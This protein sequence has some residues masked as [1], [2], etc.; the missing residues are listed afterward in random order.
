MSQHT[1]IADVAKAAGVSVTTVSRILNGNY[2]KMR[3]STRHRVEAVIK[4]LNYMPA[5]SAQRLRQ[6]HGHVI[7]VLVGDISNPFSSLLAK[8][9]DDV[10]Q[11]SGYD[12]ILMNTNNS[13]EAEARSL[14]RLYQQQVDG[15]I[16]QPDSRHFQPFNG[17]VQAGVPLVVVDREID[18]QPESVPKVTSCNKD[19]CYQ[20]GKTLVARHYQNIVTVSA[21]YAQASGQIPR[22][23]GLK[24]T[25]L[26]HGLSYHNLELKGHDRGWLIKSLG[27]LLGQL[28]GRTVVVSLMGPVLFDLL[29]CFKA[30]QLTFPDDVGLVSFDDWEWSQYVNHGIFLLKQDMEL[31]GNLAAQKLLAQIK[32]LNG[33]G[34]TFLPVQTVDRPSL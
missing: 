29:S 33:G 22:I 7:G 11:Q 6:D 23:A 24:A 9:I 16:T 4:K 26:D 31:M 3:P 14:R 30:L 18:D 13:N 10:L 17:I 28:S 1:T 21:R 2:K 34:A 19:A 25:A 27:T 5:A 32:G 8:G 20:L 12:I 15:I